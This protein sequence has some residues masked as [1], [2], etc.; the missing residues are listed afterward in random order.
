M[1]PEVRIAAIL[2]LGKA[3]GKN[4]VTDLHPLL[5]DSQDRI[6]LAAAR[7][8]A[9]FGDRKC[10]SP[11][12]RLLSS[13]EINV[14][15]S[16]AGALRGLSGKH[17]GF[18]A[19]D[20]P[21]KHSAAATKWKTWIANEGQTAKLSFPLKLFGAHSHLG[22]NT[23]LAFGYANKVVEYD[24]S[25]KEV[26]SYNKNLGGAWSAEKMANGNVL[27]AAHSQSRV[28]EVDPQ[29]N[30][31][32]EYSAQGLNAKPLANGNVLIAKQEG[33]GRSKLPATRRSFGNTRPRDIA[34]TSTDC[35]TA[36]RY[37]P[38]GAPPSWR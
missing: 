3:L 30:V 17:F 12:L 28:V 23:L 4:S 26:W 2:G 6:K 16:A 5:D 13:E 34:A 36:I 37:W 19:Y 27:I 10:L 21:K 32:W 33:G 7:A 20:T 22:G 25:G 29:G 18:A 14:R 1:N 31:V 24:P 15:S 11:L 8:V 9:D 35:K 38:A